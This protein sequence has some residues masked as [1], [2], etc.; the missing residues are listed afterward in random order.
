MDKKFIK[1]YNAVVSKYENSLENL[2]RY[3]EKLEESYKTLE[4]TKNKKYLELYNK[5]KEII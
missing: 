5:Q 1:N 4:N 3:K 2:K